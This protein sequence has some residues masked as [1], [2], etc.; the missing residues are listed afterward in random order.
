MTYVNVETGEEY[1]L[2]MLGEKHKEH[3]VCLAALNEHVETCPQCSLEESRF[4][5]KR[6]VPV[7]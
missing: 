6:A 7:R 3:A 1:P 5:K 2:E 4:E